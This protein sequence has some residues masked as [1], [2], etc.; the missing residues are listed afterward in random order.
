[1]TFL[2]P[3]SANL[4]SNQNVYIQQ[5]HFQL[6]SLKAESVPLGKRTCQSFLTIFNLEKELSVDEIMAGA[7]QSINHRL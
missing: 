4:S 6:I 3:F 1:M 5:L 7:V 2:S